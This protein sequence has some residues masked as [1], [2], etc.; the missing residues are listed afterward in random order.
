MEVWII[1]TRSFAGADINLEDTEGRKYTEFASLHQSQEI[2]EWL[3][4]KYPALYIN[5]ETQ[6]LLP[7]NLFDLKGTVAHFLVSF[8]ACILYSMN[9]SGLAIPEIDWSI[10][11]TSHINY[12][13]ST[14]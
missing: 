7:T 10:L 6:A 12:V 1:I 14:Y 2:L 8:M 4:T 9:R 13:T 11:W 3:A 5:D